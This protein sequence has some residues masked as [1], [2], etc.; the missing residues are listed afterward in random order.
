MPRGRAGVIA[1]LVAGAVMAL[2][3][4]AVMAVQSRS[5][6]T[7]PDL[8][9]AMWLGAEVADGRLTG[10][11]FLGLA[12][13]LATSAVMG[14]IAIPWLRDLSLGRTL[15]VAVV[16]AAASYPIVFT[17]VLTWVNPLMYEEAAMPLMTAAH[18]VFGLVLGGVYH[19]LRTR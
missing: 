7:N 1:G 8:I 16:Y 9:A 17:L 11:T 10:A 15:L 6:W 3:V 2:V 5:I 19:R 14:L 13:H 12:T 4:M 18:V